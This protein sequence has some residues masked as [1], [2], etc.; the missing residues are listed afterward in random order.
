MANLNIHAVAPHMLEYCQKVK[1]IVASV[2]LK[3]L[4]SA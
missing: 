4:T 1:D 2:S 3:V